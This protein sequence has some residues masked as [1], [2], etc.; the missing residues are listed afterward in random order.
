[1]PDVLQSGVVVLESHCWIH[2]LVWRT[3]ARC[4]TLLTS[5][6]LFPAL[7]LAFAGL[8]HAQSAS[9][10]PLSLIASLVSQSPSSLASTESS[11]TRG[12]TTSILL[13]F[14]APYPI[15]NAPESTTTLSASGLRRSRSSFDSAKYWQHTYRDYYAS[16]I[17]VIST[18]TLV[19]AIDCA[20]N[21]AH[22][23]YAKSDFQSFLV[24]AAGV[25]GRGPMIVTQGPDHWNF[26]VTQTEPSFNLTQSMYNQATTRTRLNITCGA[27]TNSLKTCK[28][29]VSLTSSNTIVSESA[30]SLSSLRSRSSTLDDGSEEQRKGEISSLLQN[31]S[32][33]TEVIVTVTRGVDKIPKEMLSS[34]SNDASTI[35]TTPASSS[36][37]ASPSASLS[38]GVSSSGSTAAAPRVTGAAGM[39]VMFGAAGALGAAVFGF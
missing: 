12:Q 11:T 10:S 30:D 3:P 21:S 1:M 19:Y 23:S 14:Y 37:R 7:T 18:S 25:M 9:E 24:C 20:P 28:N 32:T 26:A 16:I 2:K 4:S 34:L 13:P 35:T 33:M 6:M 31:F 22:P 27:L 5:V 8:V 36:M 15:S 17:T 39:E 38:A 29:V